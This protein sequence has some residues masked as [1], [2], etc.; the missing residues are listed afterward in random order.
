MTKLFSSILMICSY[1]ALGQVGINT[2]TPHPKSSLDVIS[3]NNNTGI[4]FPRL[5]TAQRNTIAP[6]I[7]DL[8]V[9]GLWIYNKDTKCYNY[10]QADP[11]NQWV[12]ICGNSGAVQ[13]NCNGL[14][15][16]GTPFIE[17][18]PNTALLSIP[19]TSDTTSPYAGQSISSTGVT[20]LTATLS[21]GTLTNGSGNFIF[22][23]SGTPSSSGTA[24]FPFTINGASCTFTVPVSSGTANI[25][26]AGTTVT[27]T[28]TS[29]STASGVSANVPYTLGNG[30]P[31]SAQSISSTGVTGLTAT[32]TAGNFANGNGNLIF[33]ISGTPNTSGTASFALN[34]GGTACT[35]TVDVALGFAQYSSCNISTQGTYTVATNL[36]TSNR[37]VATLNVTVA[38]R[39]RLRSQDKNGILFDSGE[40]TLTTG[41]Q[42]VT[43]NSIT[44]TSGRFPMT[45]EEV[46]NGGNGSSNQTA[47]Y[48]ITNTLTNTTLPCS[49]TIDVKPRIWQT[50][51]NTASDGIT[52]GSLRTGANNS[53]I[54]LEMQNNATF[55][56]FGIG[57]YY[58]LWVRNI[59]GT[60]FNHSIIV[61]SSDDLSGTATLTYA[62]ALGNNSRLGSLD[63]YLQSGNSQ[64]STT[65]E[66]GA[67]AGPIV[68]LPE[69]SETGMN[70]TLGNITD[71]SKWFNNLG[72][73]IYKYRLIF[74]SKDYPNSGT[75]MAIVLY[76][77]Y[78]T[79][80]SVST[81]D[82]INVTGGGN[83]QTS[84]W[85]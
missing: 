25:N 44:A 31:Y 83:P 39:I 57:G 45:A 22:S 34:M 66:V 70:I 6:T 23:I 69:N 62:G 16:S 9:D 74:N 36:T 4:L 72:T 46:S 52:G 26:C 33:T 77:I 47:T 29:G 61:R 49:A 10:W 48:T 82:P 53:M 64:P 11:N 38:G 60:S 2:N 40:L 37:L 15:R 20:G 13:L 65:G 41:S 27:G 73:R 63:V 8:A 71:T 28:L 14:I 58:K 21:A 30:G 17:S 12:E 79:T 18:L 19:Y 3:P 85:P 35:F 5:T 50:F 81:Y 55:Q 67:H 54:N 76:G 1:F 84:Y 59:S 32:I 78:T 80:T 24:S 42:T 43:L 56:L 51:S 68:P 75:N 7:G